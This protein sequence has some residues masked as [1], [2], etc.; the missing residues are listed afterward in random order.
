MSEHTRTLI[1]YTTYLI[2]TVGCLLCGV[3]IIDFFTLKGSSVGSVLLTIIGLIA[4]AVMVVFSSCFLVPTFDRIAE[5]DNR[6]P[7]LFLRPFNEDKSRTYDVIL[8]GESTVTTQGTSEDFLLALNAI[9][10]FVSIG[11]PNWESRMGMFPQGAYRIFVKNQGWQKKVAELLSKSR[12]VVLTVGESAGIEWEIEAVKNNVNHTSLLLYL[13]PRP[14]EALTK[15][16]RAKKEKAFYEEFKAMIEK[17]FPI[18]LPNFQDAI[19][20]IGFTEDGDPI[21]GQS[22]S[23]RKWWFTEM[24]R[25]STAVSDQLKH[26]LS[27]ILPDHDLSSYTI[28]GQPAMYARYIVATVLFFFG[29]GLGWIWQ[30]SDFST[31]GELR[32]L[33]N[34]GTTIINQFALVI[35]WVLIAKYFRRQWIWIIPVCIATGSVFSII[36]TLYQNRILADIN[37]VYTLLNMM[38]T[39]NTLTGVISSLLI[40]V[41]GIW[42]NGRKHSP[43]E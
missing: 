30:N 38:G 5:I 25:T 34:V 21:F 15:K 12:L 8:A 11:E 32:M 35:G 37:V 1:G 27:V 20:I 36:F 40:L 3:L 4:F 16:G 39:I 41:L 19:Y 24:D 18:H 33:F 22:T 42:L 14:T 9:G 7:V 17:R 31:L 43:S 6:P 28:I 13:P 26:V 23:K 29:L 10:P 2:G